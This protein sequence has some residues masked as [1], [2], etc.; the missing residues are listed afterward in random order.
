MSESKESEL[1]T[2][3]VEIKKI[4]LNNSVHNH[5]VTTVS[6]KTISEWLSEK[7]SIETK[8]LILY[9]DSQTL[10]LIVHQK[11]KKQDF[12]FRAQSL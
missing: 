6:K 2:S 7:L 9:K 8:G 1:D 4:D 5:V 10:D 11:D 3:P 12:L